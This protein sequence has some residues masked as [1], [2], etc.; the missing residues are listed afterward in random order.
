MSWQTPPVSETPHTPHRESHFIPWTTIDPWVAVTVVLVV[1]DVVVCVVVT[2]VDAVCVMAGVPV[3]LDPVI[4]MSPPQQLWPF[5]RVP[6][7]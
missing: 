1:V 7:S 6:L 2:V 4:V 3:P 5:G